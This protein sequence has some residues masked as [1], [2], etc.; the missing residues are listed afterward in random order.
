M[1]YWINYCIIIAKVFICVCLLLFHEMPLDEISRYKN[2][3]NVST[4]KSKIVFF[5]KTDQNVVLYEMPKRR[6]SIFNTL[7]ILKKRNS[8][9]TTFNRTRKTYYEYR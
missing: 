9:R 7:Q 1:L 4:K 8:I 6:N 5:H 2:Q 3:M